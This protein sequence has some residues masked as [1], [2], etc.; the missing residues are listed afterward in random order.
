M[1]L[2]QGVAWALGFV[3]LFVFK[4]PH[5]ILSAAKMENHCPGQWGAV[6]S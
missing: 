2:L 3:R 4:A 5:V 6:E 1:F